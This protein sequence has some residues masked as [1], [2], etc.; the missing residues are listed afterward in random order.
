[1]SKCARGK[2]QQATS[3]NH[4]LAHQVDIFV[5]MV[6]VVSMVM[7]TLMDMWKVIACAANSSPGLCG[8]ASV[9][10]VWTRIRR[11]WIYSS[12][13]GGFLPDVRV[14]VDGEASTSFC[15][16]SEIYREFLVNSCKSGFYLCLWKLTRAFCG[17]CRRCRWSLSFRV[18]VMHPFVIWLDSVCRVEA[19]ASQ[20][21][22]PAVKFQSSGSLLKLI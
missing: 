20:V 9:V 10:K 7:E 8:E 18:V 15:V 2:K 6:S 5:S 13:S 12:Q 11:N 4:K 17:I 22:E 16:T 3:P 14:W 1:M 19:A 21:F